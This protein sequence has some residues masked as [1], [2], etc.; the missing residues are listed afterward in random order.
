MNTF[1]GGSRQSELTS[2]AMRSPSSELSFIELRGAPVFGGG[3]CIP[4]GGAT[5]VFGGGVRIPG[6]GAIPGGG[7]IGNPGHGI[8][9]IAIV[10][11]PHIGCAMRA[12]G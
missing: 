5:P 1:A 10:P 8:A 7:I 4:G 3:V 6:G 2:L 11:K 12:P 9:G